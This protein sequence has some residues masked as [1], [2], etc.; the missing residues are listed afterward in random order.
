[1]KHYAKEKLF[2]IQ[3]K[4]GVISILSVQRTHDLFKGVKVEDPDDFKAV[5]AQRSVNTNS[6]TANDDGN[7]AS[8]ASSS[9]SSKKDDKKITVLDL[10]KLTKQL[11]DVFGSTKGVHGEYLTSH[12]VSSTYYSCM[13]RVPSA[14]IIRA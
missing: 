14:L 11:K 9:S 1:M 3:D 2:S 12:E 7:Q 10:Y 13:K 8:S 4:A 5:V 6:S